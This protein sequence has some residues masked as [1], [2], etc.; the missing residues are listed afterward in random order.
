MNIVIAG[1]LLLLASLA[2]CI[3]NDLLVDDFTLNYSNSTN[4]LQLPKYFQKQ[5]SSINQTLEYAS[6]I[7]SNCVDAFSFEA[8]VLSFKNSSNYPSGIKMVFVGILNDECTEFNEFIQLPT[9]LRSYSSSISSTRYELRASLHTLTLRQKQRLSTV[10]YNETQ[11]LGHEYTHLGTIILECPVIPTLETE[12][13][14]NQ[15]EVE[16]EEEK[17]EQSIEKVMDPFQNESHFKLMD[18]FPYFKVGDDC[19]ICNAQVMQPFKAFECKHGTFHENCIL[20]LCTVNQFKQKSTTCPLCRAPLLSF[21]ITNNPILSFQEAAWQARLNLRIGRIDLIQTQ[22][23]NGQFLN[24]T[25]VIY[26]VV[27]SIRYHQ[28]SAISRMLKESSALNAF[29]I[30]TALCRLS[31]HGSHDL[32]HEIKYTIRLF[33]MYHFKMIDIIGIYVKYRQWHY[34]IIFLELP[35]FGQDSGWLLLAALDNGMPIN[36]L[37]MIVQHLN[38]DQD[39]IPVTECLKAIVLK[40]DWEVLRVIT[41]FMIN[42]NDNVYKNGFRECLI[43]MLMTSPSIPREAFDYLLG[44]VNAYKL[45]RTFMLARVFGTNI[46][47][48]CP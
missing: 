38:F 3:C 26:L 33:N 11:S 4:L 6:M 8:I 21:I 5:V 20:E 43:N 28:F 23:E 45:I 10:F 9:I 18:S 1:G 29:A 36:Q 30:H 47:D 34:T 31:L 32:T 27:S 39:E 14:D 42:Q 16:V 15:V 40:K 35:G 13:G 46:E 7:E 2:N 37:E 24:E 19:S 12:I 41:G 44:G 22:I 17:V 25:A 48:R